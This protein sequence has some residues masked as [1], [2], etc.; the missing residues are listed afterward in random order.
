MNWEAFG[1]IA[2]A[3]GAAGVIVTLIYLVGQVRTNNRLLRSNS[4]RTSTELTVQIGL[5]IAES[6]DLAEL[7][8]KGVHDPD[9]LDGPDRGRFTWLMASL[10]GQ[11]QQTFVDEQLGLTTD[12]EESQLQRAY[13]GVLDSSGGRWWWTRNRS[14][15]LAAFAE[16]IDRE[17]FAD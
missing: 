2:E 8:Q 15:Y 12:D 1:S 17:M 10:V 13:A 14:R 5:K 6:R 9:Q 4:A 7:F 16:H 3:L 11:E